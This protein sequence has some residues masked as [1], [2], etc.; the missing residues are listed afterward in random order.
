[1]ALQPS[2]QGLEPCMLAPFPQIIAINQEQDFG[3]RLVVTGADE[4]LKFGQRRGGIVNGQPFGLG[5][6]L[7]PEKLRRALMQL[8]PARI[9][10]V[11]WNLAVTI[12]LV[13]RVHRELAPDL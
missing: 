3:C 11:I 4:M 5:L 13:N 9:R 12:F 7:M 6:G 1:M 2:V 8:P 10:L